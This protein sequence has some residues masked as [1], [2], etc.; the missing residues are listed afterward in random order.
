MLAGAPESAT[1]GDTPP[2]FSVTAAAARV[3]RER[4]GAVTG[5]VGER[6]R[7]H[8]TR[9]RGVDDARRG[10]RRAAGLTQ[11]PWRGGSMILNTRA[12]GVP[13]VSVARLIVVGPEALTTPAL[14]GLAR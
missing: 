6:V 8:P 14:T 4:V 3:A 12:P 11:T 1:L 5:L 9:V 10:E 13:N 2:T 7:S